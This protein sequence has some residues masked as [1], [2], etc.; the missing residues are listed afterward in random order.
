[1]ALEYGHLQAPVFGVVEREQPRYQ[2][3]GRHRRSLPAKAAFLA[4]DSEKSGVLSVDQ[5]Q[6]SSGAEVVS[7][8][9][10]QHPPPLQPTP[11][12]QRAMKDWLSPTNIAH[13]NR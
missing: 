12:Y 4:E 8:L 2:F 6:G 10:Q 11:Y 5:F 13:P 3:Q 7:I 1:M 9:G